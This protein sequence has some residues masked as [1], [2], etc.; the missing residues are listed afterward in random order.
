M[1]SLILYGIFHFILLYNFHATINLSYAFDDHSHSIF[2]TLQ[3]NTI[4]LCMALYLSHE[5]IKKIIKNIDVNIFDDNN[6]DVIK[7]LNF[8]KNFC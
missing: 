5:K 7:L 6:I 3:N 4:V 2:T 8:N 1:M